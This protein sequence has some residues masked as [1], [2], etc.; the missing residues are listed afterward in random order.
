MET[1][2]GSKYDAT[3]TT[4]DIAKRIRADIKSTLPDIK[5]SVRCKSFSGGSSIT[6]EV[7]SV[8]ASLQ[9]LTADYLAGREEFNGAAY[10]YTPDAR[11]LR[12]SLEALVAA[13]NFDGSDSMVDYFHV[14][15]YAH[16]NFDS[17]LEENERAAYAV[18]LE[19]K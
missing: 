11:A 13:Y 19:G 15:F 14:N 17:R 8:P 5:V 9:L 16:V 6:V 10:R 3:L 2:H 4:T 7:T 12:A 18:T 1:K